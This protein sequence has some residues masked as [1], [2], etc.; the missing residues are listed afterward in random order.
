MYLQ[1]H[2]SFPRVSA[3]KS[4]ITNRLFIDIESTK[5]NQQDINSIS[6]DATGGIIL[7]SRNYQNPEQLKDLCAQIH[8]IKSDIK[9]AV[10]QEGGRV[11]RFTNNFTIIPPMR[12][13]GKL[14]QKDSQTGINTAFQLATILAEELIEAGVDFTF[15]PV[16]DIDFG[17]NQAIRD[18]AFSHE[19]NIVIELAK[20]FGS[21]LGQMGMPI[22]GKHFPGH[23]FVSEDSHTNYPIDLRSLCELE[24]TEI[25]PY[26]Q[27]QQ[28]GL[29]AVMMSHITYQNLDQ[30]PA[31]FSCYWINYLREKLKFNGA[32]FSDDLSMQA[33]KY[34]NDNLETRC[35]RALNA[36]CDYL[37]IC[38]DP[39]GLDKYLNKL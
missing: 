20:A 7:F 2:K 29:N 12:T 6:H 35:Q 36:G 24:S 9:I 11:Q 39:H 15:A 4:D 32:V 1:T 10:D 34:Q 25:Y 30:N 19:A 27:H 16:L 5:L 33:V 17:N 38:N 18:R 31:S 28:I 21:G 8:N 13:I 26:S 14:Y 22:I 3:N 37:I 23:G